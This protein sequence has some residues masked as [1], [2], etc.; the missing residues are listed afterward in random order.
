MPAEARVTSVWSKQKLFVA[1][2]LL[3][4]GGWFFWDGAVGYPHSNERWRAHEQL[5]KS[6]QEAQWPA[7]AKSRGWTT[8]VPHK[9]LHPGE[10]HAQWIFGSFTSLLGLISLIYWSTQKGRTL[11]TDEEA[12][13]SPAGTR[14][15]FAA[16]TGLGKKN[17]DRK[18]LATVLYQ[19]NGRKGRFI[20]DDYKFDYDATHEILDEIEGKLLARQAEK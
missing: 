19:I 7:L 18:G 2:F 6:G 20:I 14:V 5:V 1:V 16:V 11:R 4:L 3:A 10:I 15:P 12:V 17:W 9:F 8:T 13:Y